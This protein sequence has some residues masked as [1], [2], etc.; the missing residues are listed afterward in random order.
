MI[1][2]ILRATLAVSLLAGGASFA[3][4]QSADTWGG[5]TLVRVDAAAGTIA[6]KQ[7]I[8]EQTY[9]LAPEVRVQDGRKSLETKDLSG[10]IGRRL[11]VKY[12]TDGESRI[13]ARI[14]LQGG[15]KAAV[16][17]AAGKP[18]ATESAT[19]R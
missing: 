6:V 8:H 1:R 5:G 11:T 7:G 17:A 15:E 16:A 9:K 2:S 14:N 12:A 10:S 13:A 4:A 3:A 18:A 19:P